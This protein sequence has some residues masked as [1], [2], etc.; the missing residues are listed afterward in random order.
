MTKTQARE[1]KMAQA[2]IAHGMPDMAARIISALIR[3]AMRQRDADELRALA[4]SL[5]VANHP[6]FIA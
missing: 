6:E 2:A 4:Q 3:C 5:G 1:V